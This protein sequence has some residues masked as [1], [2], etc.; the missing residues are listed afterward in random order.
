M[1]RRLRDVINRVGVSDNELGVI[2]RAWSRKH[3]S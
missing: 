2:T 3:D 1:R